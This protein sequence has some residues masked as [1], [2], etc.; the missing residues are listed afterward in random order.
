MLIKLS[1]RSKLPIGFP[2]QLS[3]IILGAAVA[4]VVFGFFWT[5]LT[6]PASLLL[7]SG[8]NSSDATQTVAFLNIFIG[9]MPILMGLLCVAW[10]FTK[11]VEER[12]YGQIL[13]D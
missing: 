12:E 10:A 9:L 8:M 6:L 5:I 1:H 3:Q 11:A 4:A 13:P 2:I 7:I